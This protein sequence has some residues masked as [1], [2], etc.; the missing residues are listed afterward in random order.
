MS[1]SSPKR[2]LKIVD[3]TSYLPRPVDSSGRP[4]ANDNSLWVLTEDMAAATF[5]QMNK[6]VLRYCHSTGAWFQWD[7]NI[8]SKDGTNAVLYGVRQLA[9]KLSQEHPPKIQTTVQKTSFVNGVDRFCRADPVFAVTIE[10]W[11]TDRFK[12]GTP[13]G[14]VDLRTGLLAPGAQLDCI[15]MTTA[16]APIEKAECPLWLRFLNQTT[17]NDAELIRFLQQWCGYCLTGTTREHALVFVYGGG[18][19][20]KSVFLNTVTGIFGDYAKTAAMDTFI[21][22]HSDKHPTELAML[23]G[24]RL[25]T[26][27]ENEEGRAWAEARIKQLTGGDPISARFM[28]QDFFTFTPQFK[29]TIIGNHKPVLH[30]V[31]DAARRRFNIIPFLRKPAVPDRELESKLMQEW[32]AIFRWMIHGCLDWQANGLVQPES[33]IAATNSYFDEQ[34]LFGQWLVDKCDVDPERPDMWDR[35][36]DLFVSWSAYAAISGEKPGSAKSFAD[37]LRSRGC[38][39]KRT[40]DSRGFTGIRLKMIESRSDR[41]DA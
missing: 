4:V 8:W 25:V 14:T 34:D 5:A 26:A 38:L 20:G 10:V 18:G 32:P 28:R 23:R 13:A 1:K 31:D 40:A 36:S 27:A 16:V 21:A 15:T 3:A 24:A 19:N 37:S 30:N 39:S 41:Y 12:V 6:G 29:L 9:R 17:G 2:N 11:D 35:S 22:S 33:I 7:G